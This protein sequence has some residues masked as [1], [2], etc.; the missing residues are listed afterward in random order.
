MKSKR[1]PRRC[2]MLRFSIPAPHLPICRYCL[3]GILGGMV[4]MDV[5]EP[6]IAGRDL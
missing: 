4:G 1:N 3:M 6:E 5:I 2:H